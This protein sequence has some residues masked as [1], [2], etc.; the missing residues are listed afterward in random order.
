M[1]LNLLLPVVQ[2]LYSL[3]PLYAQEIILGTVPYLSEAEGVSVYE[4]LQ[5]GE[6]LKRAS[7]YAVHAGENYAVIRERN[8]SVLGGL[9]PV[10]HFALVE[11]TS[12]AVYDHAVF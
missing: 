4:L 12:A 6:Y 1:S 9:A 10:Y 2:T 5:V 8:I 7:E 11:H 3:I